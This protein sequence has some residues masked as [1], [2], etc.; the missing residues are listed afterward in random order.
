M[1]KEY[2]DRHN[3]FLVN[4]AVTHGEYEAQR[5]AKLANDAESMKQFEK[6]L[7]NSDAAIIDYWAVISQRSESAKAKS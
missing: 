2:N 6:M 4:P 1:R 3:A 5:A 7:A